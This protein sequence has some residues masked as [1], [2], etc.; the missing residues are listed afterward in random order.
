MRNINIV[1]GPDLWTSLTPSGS[2]DFVGEFDKNLTITIWQYVQIIVDVGNKK[3]RNN[4]M[5]QRKIVRQ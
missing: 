4:L 3:S 1:V 2:G 5:I